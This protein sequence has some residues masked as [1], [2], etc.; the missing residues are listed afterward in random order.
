MQIGGSSHGTSFFHRSQQH[1][2]VGAAGLVGQCLALQRMTRSYE[3][4]RLATRTSNLQG[5]LERPGQPTALLRDV[6]CSLCF[7]FGSSRVGHL[8][9]QSWEPPAT[10]VIQRAKELLSPD[11]PTSA[12]PRSHGKTRSVYVYIYIYLCMIYINIICK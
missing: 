12:H 2:P 1:C 9:E 3:V 4:W 7:S 6:F 8:F 11:D 10:Q 5:P